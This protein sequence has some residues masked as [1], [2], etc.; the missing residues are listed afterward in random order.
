VNHEHLLSSIDAHGVARV[1]VNNPAKLNCLSAG[2]ARTLAAAMERLWS[3]PKLRVVVLTGA[4]DKAFVG[5]ANLDEL[6]ALNPASA[7][8]FIT[9]LHHCC[10]AMRQCPVPV[11]ARVNGW[12]LGAGL[13]LAA[14]C[15][16]RIASD[17]AM[18]GMPEVRL[19]IPS[20]IEAALL[21]RLIGAGRARWLVLT[22]ETIG[23]DEAMRWGFLERVV[24]AGDLDAEVDRTVEA[25]LK[26]SNAATRLQK[27]LQHAYEDL[28]LDE[29]IRESIDA[30]A[31]SYASGEP[32]NLIRKFQAQRRR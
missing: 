13:E 19:G 16:I 3:E 21:P 25:I 18:F 6:G 7:R 26:N 31:Q 1:T 24:L 27:S 28:P 17:K 32:Q 14:S 29:A 15:D 4:G 5:G 9:G 10:A 2:I 30:F 8:E 12:C 11:I 20:V 22:G 23:A